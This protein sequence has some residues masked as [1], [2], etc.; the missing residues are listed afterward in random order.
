MALDT[1]TLSIPPAWRQ[2]AQYLG[3]RSVG[4]WIR[5]VVE[6]VLDVKPL[7]FVPLLPLKWRQESFKVRRTTDGATYALHE[8]LGLISGPFGIY[9]GGSFIPAVPS[10]EHVFTLAHVPTGERLATLDKVRRCKRL[11]KE[12]APLPGI[13]W[14]LA[15]P[16][17]VRIEHSERAVDL[18]RDYQRAAQPERSTEHAGVGR[19]RPCL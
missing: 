14:H 19:R 15:D 6:D 5:D 10:H 18:I 8:V 7:R 2:V 4:A 3:F 12:L 11:A 16:E 13:A 9:S 1:I 17:R